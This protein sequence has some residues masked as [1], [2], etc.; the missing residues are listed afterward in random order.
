M[1]MLMQIC[2]LQPRSTWDHVPWVEKQKPTVPVTVQAGPAYSFF[3]LF[4]YVYVKGSLS[5]V[6]RG[7]NIIA[8]RRRKNRPVWIKKP[9]GVGQPLSLAI[10]THEPNAR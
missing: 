5:Y 3:S 9:A 1:C 6:S 4:L 7:N 8:Q 2:I 10:S